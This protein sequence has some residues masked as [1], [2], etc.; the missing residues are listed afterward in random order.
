M[1]FALVDFNVKTVWLTDF[2]ELSLIAVV[3]YCH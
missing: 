1:D 2:I 3:S